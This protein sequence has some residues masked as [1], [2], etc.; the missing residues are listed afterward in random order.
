MGRQGMSFLNPNSTRRTSLL[1]LKVSVWPFRS[2]TTRHKNKGLKHGAIRR[3]MGWAGIVQML[4]SCL[5][6]RHDGRYS[7]TRLDGPC[8]G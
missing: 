8:L 2:G 5:K 6:L 1:D 7:T 4:G 3:K